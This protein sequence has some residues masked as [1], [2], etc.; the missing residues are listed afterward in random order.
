MSS[1]RRPGKNRRHAGSILV[2]ALAILLG[3]FA[4]ARR[5]W[6]SVR[7]GG[8]PNAWDIPVLEWMVSHRNAAAT[9]A[10]WF[11]TVL[12]DTPA[13]T[14]LA[15]CVAVLFSWRARSVWPGVLIALTAAGSV[16]LTLVLKATL[17]RARPSLESVLAPIPSS[18]AFPSGHTL[19][20]IAILG[21]IGY[22]SI[23]ILR[24]LWARILLVCTLACLVLCVGWSRIYL[25]HHWLTDVLGG[26]LIGGS[27]VAVIILLHHFVL[28]KNR[29]TVRWLQL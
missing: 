20:S 11:F 29:R 10:A 17:G 27:W 25:G 14:I 24:S 16:A 8:V 15:L 22:L 28:L 21:I 19:N 18:F 2:F 6:V 7:A 23:L 1:P 9:D 4:V 12:G 5:V 13:M 3:L 26:L